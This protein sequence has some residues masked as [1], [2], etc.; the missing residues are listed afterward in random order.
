MHQPTIADLTIPK[1]MCPRCGSRMRLSA[2]EPEPTRDRERMIFSC[3]CGF[4]YRQSGAIDDRAHILQRAA[5]A[6]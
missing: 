4:D 6:S 1:I 2:I 3:G 5:R